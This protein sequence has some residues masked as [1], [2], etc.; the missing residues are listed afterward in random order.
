MATILVT[1][2]DGQLGNEF[3]R[4]AE[5]E[6]AHDFHF[7]DLDKL[8]ITDSLSVTRLFKELNPNF[9]L[10]CAAYTA[11]DKAEDEPDLA[12]AVNARGVQ[13]LIDACEEVS[14]IFIHYSTDYVFNGKN[15]SPY[16]ES[17]PVDPIGVYGKTKRAG[18]E[19]VIN[20]MV[21]GVVIRTSWVYSSFGNNFVK[22]MMR[23]G[24]DRDNL[25]VIFDQVGT[26][27]NARDLAQATMQI[28]S[29][30]EK[31][32]GQQQ[33]FHFSNEGVTSWYDFAL[34]IFE[35]CGIQCNVKPILT[36]EY[37]TK[38][39]RPHYSVLDKSKVKTHF[40]LEIPHWKQ[41][42]KQAV[43]EIISS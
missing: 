4:I 7:V 13:N 24:N 28:L 39:D 14:S 34:E 37:P 6:E 11:V 19:A 38:A 17:D 2:S 41:S 3:Q 25:N 21:S 36:S 1:G 20:S 9:V 43:E 16:K 31:L 22:T 29:Q 30:K 27:T 40:G 32:I 33:V 42:L 5:T 23:L 10:N 26:P 18:E 35:L 8:D 15:Y 12:M